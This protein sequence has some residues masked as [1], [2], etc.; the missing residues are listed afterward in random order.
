MPGSGMRLARGR[1]CIVLLRS[2]LLITISSAYIV[3]P[4]VGM[5]GESG[6]RPDSVRCPEC[7][8]MAKRQLNNKY[9]CL[10]H[11]GHV[12]KMKPDGSPELVSDSG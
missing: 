9:K 10:D 3:G 6:R 4:G 5:P 11:P 7:G 1:R 2:L 8:G 12:L